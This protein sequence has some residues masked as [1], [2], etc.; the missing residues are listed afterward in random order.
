MEIYRTN[1]F[2]N[3]A[4]F[5]GVISAC[6]SEVTVLEDSLFVTVDP[7]LPFCMLYEGDIQIYNITAPVDPE[8]FT[9]EHLTTT[10]QQT[11]TRL[12]NTAPPLIVEEDNTTRR[13]D[14]NAHT[15]STTA[16]TKGRH[17]T[18]EGSISTTFTTVTMNEPTTTT[19]LLGKDIE[20]TTSSDQIMTIGEVPDKKN[21]VSIV[22]VDS[23]WAIQ[24]SASSLALFF[25]LAIAMFVLV[26]VLLCTHKRKAKEPES[27]NIELTGMR[28]SMTETV[29]S[30][31]AS[32]IYISPTHN[33][34]S[35][36]EKLEV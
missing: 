18:P 25:A 17:T 4:Q 30:K 7:L 33:N 34:Y 19:E 28:E 22:I 8:V 13:S 6:N 14:V 12:A 11:T 21:D 2:N 1:I 35:S 31:Y 23:K 24:L 3:M 29:K 5:G 36:E 20:H 32:N 15:Q 10:E 26:V 9:L 16:T 27:A